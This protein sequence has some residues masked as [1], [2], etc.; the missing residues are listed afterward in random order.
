MN[1]SKVL[2]STT[3]AAGFLFATQ[4]AANADQ[5]TVQAGDTVSKIANEYNTTVEAI[6]AANN[7][8]DVNLIYVGEVLEVT[9]GQQT[10]DAQTTTDTAVDTQA[11]APAQTYTYSQPQSSYQASNYYSANQTTNYSY[12][13]PQSSYSQSANT[14]SSYTSNV[15]SSSDEAAKAWIAN[16]ESGNNYNARNGQ[17]IGKYQLTASYLNGDYSAANQERV[18]NQYVASR[19]GSWTAAK[20]HWDANGWY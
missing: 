18:A 13:Q 12:S 17:Y 10:A 15:A 4:A 9:P 11:S 16:R 8:A 5:V 3:A 14:A 1:L 2:L 7:M 20:A 19:Y 6:E